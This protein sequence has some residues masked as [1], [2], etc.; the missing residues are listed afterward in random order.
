MRLLCDGGLGPQIQV[1][2]TEMAHN[3][4]GLPS[5]L[6]LVDDLG[7]TRCVSG[8]LVSQGR[9]RESD[10]VAP[11]T[12]EQYERLL[13]LYQTDPAFRSRYERVGNIAALE[14][15]TKV[16]R[17]GVAPHGGF[18]LGVERLTQQLLDIKNIRDAVLFPRT[19]E[20]YLP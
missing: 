8:T 3:F 13:V 6:E 9:A 4:S 11:P 19:P 15:F 1:A 10:R 20:R 7:I 2:F 5:L 17:Y 16:F 14:W 18:C 12:P